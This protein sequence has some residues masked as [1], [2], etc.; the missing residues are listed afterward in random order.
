M[1]G[2]RSK[3]GVDDVRTDQFGFD[4]ERNTIL[5]EPARRV[6]RCQ[7]AANTAR[8]I[9]KCRLDRVPAVKHGRPIDACAA[10]ARRVRE[11]TGRLSRYRR[12]PG[13]D[14]QDFGAIGFLFPM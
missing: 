4:R 3:A 6:L 13:L 11:A 5:G 2:V 9:F 8:G 14:C 1:D 10:E 7:Q 12:T